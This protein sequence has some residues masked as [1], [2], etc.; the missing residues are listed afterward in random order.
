MKFIRRLILLMLVFVL[1][2][3]GLFLFHGH[4]QYEEI[5]QQADITYLVQQ[6]ESDENFVSYDQLPENLVNATVS[7]EDRRYFEHGGVDYIGLLRAIV[8]QFD[9]DFL[10]SGGSTI[11]Q[12][13]AKNLYSK[14]DSD[15]LGWKGAEFFF[16]RELEQ[17]YSKE[18]IFAIYVNIINYGDNN[19]GIYEAAW[20]YF[21][22]DVSQLD[23]A[24]CSILA[25]IPQSPSNYELSGHYDN[26]KRRQQLVLNAMVSENYI[27]QD[28]ADEAYEEVVI[29]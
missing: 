13:T 23:L 26:A 22:V 25:G 11:T 3:T 12:Q 10:K 16:A 19:Q 14:F 20:N 7:I 18:E 5:N 27:T 4:N 9:N 29:Y 21:G 17:N 2:A 1:G 8:S 6:V 28:Q 24:Q 15:F